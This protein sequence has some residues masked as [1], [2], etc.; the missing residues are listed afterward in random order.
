MYVW[1]SGRMKLTQ[2]RRWD[3]GMSPLSLSS[4]KNIPL[5]LP[6]YVQRGKPK[7]KKKTHAEAESTCTCSY[8][9][10]MISE[11]A[12]SKSKRASPGQMF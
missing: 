11:K 3:G 8:G 7:P 4:P 12:K 9:I 2:H 6:F 5:G 10:W 1:V